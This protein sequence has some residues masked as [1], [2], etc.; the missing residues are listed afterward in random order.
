M[1]LRSSKKQKT[2]K[3]A[4]RTEQGLSGEEAKAKGFGVG[5][6]SQ[7]TTQMSIGIQEKSWL[8]GRLR[9]KGDRRLRGQT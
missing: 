5:G 2:S 4:S 1:F 6:V 7:K 8:R 9:G 3:Q